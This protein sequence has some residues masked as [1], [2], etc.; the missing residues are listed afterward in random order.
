VNLTINAAEARLWNAMDAATIELA[1]KL[2]N[3]HHSNRLFRR[4][5][6]A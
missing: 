3:D 2:A 5:E 1:R 6:T 4:H